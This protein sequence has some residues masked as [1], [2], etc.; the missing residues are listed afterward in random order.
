[1]EYN[2]VHLP[3]LALLIFLGLPQ[4]SSMMRLRSAALRSCSFFSSSAAFLRSNN[5]L[6]KYNT[7][8]TSFNY[9]CI[10]KPNT[11]PKFL[12]SFWCHETFLGLLGLGGLLHTLAHLSTL[13]LNF[14]LFSLLS[15]Y[16]K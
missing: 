16:D 2:S 1:M 11:Y 12:L 9:Y 4:R 13:A 10:V 8:N 14:G 5:Y 3:S 15:L 6:S 7:F